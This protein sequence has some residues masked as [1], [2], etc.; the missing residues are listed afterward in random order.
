MRDDLMFKTNVS[1][2]QIQFSLESN[3]IPEI[4][5]GYC[6]RCLIEVDEMINY[7]GKK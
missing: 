6:N 5:F 2:R 3:V 7:S 4:R 1:D